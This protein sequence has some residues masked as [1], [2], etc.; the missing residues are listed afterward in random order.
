MQ[1]RYKVSKKAG[2]LQ[3]AMVQQN[4]APLPDPSYA[5]A[6]TTGVNLQA[7]TRSS[8]PPAPMPAP[9]RQGRD[10]NPH[11]PRA[12]F[13]FYTVEEG[14]R[15]L[16]TERDGRMEVIEGP[17]RVW[18]RG[19]SFQ[20]MSHYVAHPGEFLVVRFRDGRQEHLSGPTER[21]L[22]PRH[23]LSVECEEAVQLSDKEALVVYR[24]QP[25]GVD[26]RIV[27]GPAAFVPSPG[28]W[29]HTFSWHGSLGGAK[30]PNALVFQKLWLMPDQMYHDVAEVRTADDAEVTIRLM[31]F[32]ELTDVERMLAATHDPIGD[33]VNAATSDVVEFLSRHTFES[34]KANTE[35]LNELATYRQLVERAT[36]CG[37]ALH[38]V[39]YRGYGA[40][41]A[42]QRMHDEAAQARTRLQL[43][44][45]TQQQA[46]EVEDLKL[47]RQLARATRQRADEEAALLHRL[48][49]EREQH[50]TYRLLRQR[51]HEAEHAAACAA[52]ARQRDHLAGLRDL[53]VDLT[54]Y[55]TRGAPDQILE[56]RGA[57]TPHVH[58]PSSDAQTPS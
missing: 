48:A 31:I 12:S 21:W 7:L 23:H 9:A 14:Q 5:A 55:L 17:R 13:F 26:R 42:L 33:F 1:E 2:V 36:Q 29:M 30:V 3:D 56:I 22:D 39:V 4:I 44:R 38:K 34:F 10:P 50:D 40:P 57:A 52:D 35:R 24:E 37:Y 32:F 54:R 53:G 19:R 8:P 18:R 6:H 51:D 27:Y 15:V 46:Q 28:E 25:G 41:P 16:M 49:Q 45:A 47:E 43:E 20:A 11:R 58:L